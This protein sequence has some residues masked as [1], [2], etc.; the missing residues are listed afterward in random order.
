MMMDLFVMFFFFMNFRFID[1]LFYEEES[2]REIME[3]LLR[4][5]FFDYEEFYLVFIIYGEI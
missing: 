1:G 3:D 4:R 2:Y 5:C